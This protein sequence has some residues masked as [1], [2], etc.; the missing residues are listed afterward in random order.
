[1]EK[2]EQK[3]TF[4]FVLLCSIFYGVMF[5]F[6][7]FA[8]C[9]LGMIADADLPSFVVLG[10]VCS[11]LFVPLSML[12]SIVLMVRKYLKKDYTKAKSYCAIPF[13]VFFGAFLLSGVFFK[14]GRFVQS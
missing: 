12:V 6:V 1:M 9:A 14:I 10:I 2:S 7:F 4:Y 3:K 11:F 13:W 5:P 8:S